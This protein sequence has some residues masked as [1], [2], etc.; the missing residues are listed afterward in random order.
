MTTSD[1]ICVKQ[2]FVHLKHKHNI[3]INVNYG[4]ILDVIGEY[5]IHLDNQV[6]VKYIN[7]SVLE[8]YMIKINIDINLIPNELIVDLT[9]RYYD[10]YLIQCKLDISSLPKKPLTITKYR[11]KKTVK[12]LKTLKTLKGVIDLNKDNNAI[13]IDFEMYE[14]K[15]NKILEIGYVLFD[16]QT[17]QIDEHHH[18]IIK[19]HLKYKNGK[20]VPDNRSQYQHGCSIEL[21]L[22]Q[23]FNQLQTTISKSSLIL[24]HGSTHDRKILNDYIDPVVYLSKPFIDTNT[25]NK[26]LT[27]FNHNRKLCDVAV[28]WGVSIKDVIFHNAG[29]DADITAKIFI[30]MIK[31][32]SDNNVDGVA[33][34]DI[35]Y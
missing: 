31:Q 35:S 24:A 22:E 11:P 27:N 28:E 4:R 26:M 19:E 29:N 5:V 7:L 13:S 16:I 3:T 15:Q 14:V 1:V 21:S 8:Q 10:S 17:G 20:Y 32:L 2:L 30:N 25:L 23:A 9:K 12:T 34:S 18:L 33:L 6:L